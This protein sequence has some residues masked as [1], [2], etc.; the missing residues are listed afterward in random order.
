MLPRLLSLL[1]RGSFRSLGIVHDVLIAAIAI[2]LSLGLAFGFRI[3][4]NNWQIWSLI[5][6]FTALSAAMFPLF[7]LNSGA[8]RYASL[9]D[10]LSIVKAVTAINVVFLAGHFILF[11][12]LYLPRSSLVM[13][14]FIMIVGLG[15]PR[16]AYRL[17]K[18]R[19]LSARFFD[20]S[21]IRV[22]VENVVIYGFTDNADLFIRDARRSHHGV[23][24]VGLVDDK[25]KNQGRQLHGVKVL[26]ALADLPEIARRAELG[27]TPINQLIVAKAQVP[28]AELA[29]VVEVAA[30]LKIAVKRLPDISRAGDLGEAPIEV[31]PVSLEDLLGR[32]EIRLDIDEVA[33]LIEGR[34]IAVTGA[35]GSIG[36]ELVA[37][38]AS[39]KPKRLVLI[40]AGEFNLYSIGRRMADQHPGVETVER[41]A[42]VRQRARIMAIFDEWKPEV[43]FHAAALKHVPIVEENPLE[44]IETNLLGSRNVA[45]AALGCGALAFVMV[46]TDKAVNPTNVMGATKRAAEAYCQ[47]LDLGQAGT[48]FMTVRFGNVM[49]SAGS[50]IPL[51]QNQLSRGGPLTV[52]DPDITRFFMTIPEASRLI[53]HAAGH[54]IADRAAEGQIFVLDMGE[55][56]RIT[57]LAER[58]I[59]LAGLRP[60]KDIRIEYTGLRKGE[61]LYEE[62]FGEGETR[63]DTGLPGLLIARS[64]V[65]DVAFLR[66][67]FEAI[68]EAIAAGDAPA[69][70]ALLSDVVPEF[71]RARLSNA[72]LISPALPAPRPEA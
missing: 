66:A 49:G 41:V 61:K 69:A 32:R 48:R 47:A 50:V 29:A 54:G 12:G 59:Q 33:R 68:A 24:I 45:D 3:T 37:Q 71:G 17:W 56:I 22:P 65:S 23:H 5:V 2:S 25:A 6:A 39:F 31:L 34:C 10:V 58:L 55:P 27:A 60:Y 42:D 70:V 46:S 28:P 51:F 13:T 1:P 63:E 15:G 53:L 7:S 14:W 38:I 67:R 35:G 30:P 40:D 9:L 11:R 26:G 16:L 19:G 57:E 36:S 18:E 43:I 8:W 64:R 21:G 20:T 52:T 4:F 72:A 62:L 44:G